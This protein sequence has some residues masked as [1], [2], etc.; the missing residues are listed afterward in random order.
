VKFID[1]YKGYRV[2]DGLRWGVESICAVLS[3]HGALIAP[4]TYYDARARTPSAQNERDKRLKQQIS[5]VHRDNYP[6][7]PWATQSLNK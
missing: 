6:R 2:D 1:E 5:K 4:S 7:H 3:E